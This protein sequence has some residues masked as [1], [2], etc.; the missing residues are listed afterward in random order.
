MLT[1]MMICRGDV[2]A[3]ADTD[4]HEHPCWCDADCRCQLGAVH[5]VTPISQCFA[6]DQSV[7]RRRQDIT[8]LRRSPGS[9]HGQQ[10]GHVVH[11]D[12]NCAALRSVRPAQ[13]HR[14]T[15]PDAL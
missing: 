11:A 3:H 2:D 9:A 13:H 8:T 14:F 4:T 1:L 5:D 12:H 10:R 7:P 15:S 6:D